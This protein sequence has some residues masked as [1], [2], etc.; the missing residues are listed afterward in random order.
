MN[1][2]KQSIQYLSQFML[3]ERF[4]TLQRVVGMRTR[5]ITVCLEDIY[6]SQNAS[7][8]LRSC[9][10]FGLQDVHIVEE[11][12]S[13]SLNKD[14]VLGTDKWLTLKK[15]GKRYPNPSMEAINNLRRQGYRIIAT[16]PSEGAATINNFDLEKGK[17]AIFFGTEL[18]GLSNTVMEQADEFLH[19][20]MYGFVESLNISVCAAVTVQSLTNK[21]RNSSIEWQLSEYERGELLLEW[22]KKSV[23]DSKNILQRQVKE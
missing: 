5:H 23:K 17:A 16:N 4:E 15:Y 8:V 20:P 19:I 7:A 12:N 14:I 13:L 11:R 21:L 9:D 18:T 3:P 6:Q 22:M 1:D 2:I 10:A